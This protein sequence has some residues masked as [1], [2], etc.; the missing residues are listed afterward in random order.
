MYY[1]AILGNDR[2]TS[3]HFFASLA[4][5]LALT[6]YVSVLTSVNGGYTRR[7][8]SCYGTV[9][10]GRRLAKS[11]YEESASG[12]AA[13]E[14]EGSVAGEEDG[15]QVIELE[16]INEECM[17]QNEG[18]TFLTTL[19]ETRTLTVTRTRPGAQ[20]VTISIDGCL[21]SPMPFNAPTC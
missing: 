7:S 11:L 8:P 1:I 17:N 13:P 12:S 20:T 3:V 5:L 16:G 2:P 4:C 19:V 18:V 10:R 14:L 21:P 6:R 15:M 9:S